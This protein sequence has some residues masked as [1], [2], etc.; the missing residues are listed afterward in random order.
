M[1]L[2]L[3]TL[4]VGIGS[5]QPSGGVAPVTLNDNFNDNSRNAALW[6]LG[7]FYEGIST[8]TGTVNE[9][10]NRLEVTP[11][12]STIGSGGYVTANTWD[13]T[14]SSV[15]V[16]ASNIAAQSGNQL[17]YLS[18]GADADNYI[19][20]IITSGVILGRQRIAGANSGNEFAVTYSPTTHAWIRI[21]HV[22]SGNL[23]KWH[24]APSTAA[25]PPGAG[26]WVEVGS[27]GFPALNP[28]ALKVAIGSG[29]SGSDASPGLAIFDGFN[30]AT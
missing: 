15:Y 21:G 20:F 2:G 22:T 8:N 11:A 18:L 16:K 17:S 10:N 9:A 1:G 23:V 12:G 7:G 24:V 29:C 3:S 13:L 19:T 28:A 27:N 30:S 14:N 25:N 5:Q 6:S 4:T 26:E